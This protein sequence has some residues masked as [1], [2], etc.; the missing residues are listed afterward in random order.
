MHA[1][2]K[3]FAALGGDLEPLLACG[4]LLSMNQ[5]VRVTAGPSNRGPG[6]GPCAHGFMD[7]HILRQDCDKETLLRAAAIQ[8]RCVAAVLPG[9]GT[10]ELAREPPFGNFDLLLVGR[11]SVGRTL[12]SNPAY[13]NA[14]LTRF[15]AVL[16]APREAP[17][18]L[19]RSV[20]ILADGPP[21]D[22]PSFDIAR[23]LFPNMESVH[24]ILDEP[25]GS[26]QESEWRLRPG[27]Q[28]PVR[29]SGA[30]GSTD[31][32]AAAIPR[33]GG[34]VLVVERPVRFWNRISFAWRLSGLLDH[35]PG[36]MLFTP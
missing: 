8:A 15:R 24:L 19:G 12:A 16:V 27:C 30:G 9:D 36:A 13:R 18:C 22:L 7:L 25:T 4:W 31:A 29:V 28:C 17:S 5:G 35:A 32:L 20:S 6:A 33:D 1:G 34:H 23:R 10:L 26:D 21:R 11:P 2:A 3:V 14:D